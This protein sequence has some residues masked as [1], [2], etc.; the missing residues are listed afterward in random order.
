MPENERIPAFPRISNIFKIFKNAFKLNKPEPTCRRTEPVLELLPDQ[1]ALP[2]A[3]QG[4]VTL[5]AEQLEALARLLLE[6][7]ELVLAL[8]D[9]EESLAY[10]FPEPRLESLRARLQGTDDE[11]NFWKVDIRSK[12]WLRKEKD[13]WISSNRHPVT[14]SVPSGLTEEIEGYVSEFIQ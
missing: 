5:T 8:S 6:T 14:L 7:E 1:R 9:A 3:A 12:G 13:N 2:A 11:G 10:K 4:Y